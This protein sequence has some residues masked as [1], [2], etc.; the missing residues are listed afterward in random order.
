M[1]QWIEI[2][3]I[4]REY[5]S[6]FSMLFNHK[7]CALF[8]KWLAQAKA[9]NKCSRLMVNRIFQ[10]C[11]RHWCNSSI[12]SLNILSSTVVL[13]IRT[14]LLE[15]IFHSWKRSCLILHWLH[16]LTHYRKKHYLN[17]K[18]RRRSHGW[19]HHRLFTSLNLSGTTDLTIERQR[20][21]SLS[22]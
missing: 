21:T 8:V 14:V 4:T 9:V 12:F 3:E 18:R 6:I 1:Q 5:S 16:F 17:D 15:N 22:C 7:V 10:Q 11:S 19:L 13:V 2:L 20:T